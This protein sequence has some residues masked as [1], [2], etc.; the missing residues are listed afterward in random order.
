MGN[1]TPTIAPI[2]PRWGGQ[3]QGES[4]A[5]AAGACHAPGDAWE[6]AG[7]CDWRGRRWP[8]RTGLTPIDDPVNHIVTGGRAGIGPARVPPFGAF[9]MRTLWPPRR[10]LLLW[11]C[12]ALSACHRPAAP[13]GGGASPD[14]ARP[15]LAVLVYFDQLRGD[16]L[17]RWADLFGEGGFRRLQQEGA[18]FRNCHYPYAYTV[19]GAGH[20]SVATG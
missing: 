5:T 17:S 4:G 8:L 10:G 18:W 14:A 19:T 15:R 7:R 2:L 3:L 16:Y 20:A 13:G 6:G 1:N 9:T 11:A 12:L